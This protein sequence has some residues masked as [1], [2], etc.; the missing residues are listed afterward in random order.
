MSL[1]RRMY[2]KYKQLLLKYPYRVQAVQIV[3][4]LGLGDVIAQTVDPRTE[5]YNGKRT[6][7]F[8]SAGVFMGPSVH[9]WYIILERMY[10]QSQGMKTV[11]KKV[12]TD[13]LLFAPVFLAL[14]IVYMQILSGKDLDHIKKVLKNEYPLLLRD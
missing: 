14:L 13:Q 3:G 9:A 4:L 7:K 11:L 6:L 10:G 1:V 2:C 8:M 5:T 12:A